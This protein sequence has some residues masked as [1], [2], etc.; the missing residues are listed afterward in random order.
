MA[1]AKFS[2]ALRASVPELRIPADFTKIIKPCVIRSS[3]VNT[4]LTAYRSGLCVH[5]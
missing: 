5:F 1:C 4:L 3:L 2:T